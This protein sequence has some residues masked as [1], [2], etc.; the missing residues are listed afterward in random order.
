ML[1]MCP[2]CGKL[3]QGKEGDQCP[4]CKLFLQPPSRIRATDDEDDTSVVSG[5]PAAGH[6]AVAK[7]VKNGE[8]GTGERWITFLRALLWVSFGLFCFVDLYYSFRAFKSAIWDI[9]NGLGEF[10]GSSLLAGITI[11][12]GGILVAFITLA[13]GMVALDVA[14]NIRRSANNTSHILEILDRQ[15][16]R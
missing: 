13:A 10:A 7:R 3:V 11:L 15:G 4:D 2:K 12:L 6:P 9:T 16:K 8:A 14:E 5:S 1:M